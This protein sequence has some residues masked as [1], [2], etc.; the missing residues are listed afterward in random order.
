[1]T[2]NNI[3]DA[4]KKQLNSAQCIAL[5]YIPIVVSVLKGQVKIS[6]LFKAWLYTQSFNLRRCLWAELKK[7]FSQY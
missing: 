4:P 7:A 6:C 5:G 3:Y 2:M 1:M